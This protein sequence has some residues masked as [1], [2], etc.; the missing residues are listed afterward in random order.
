MAIVFFVSSAGDT[1]LAKA[2]INTLI[3][4]GVD[5]EIHLIPLTSAA[6]ERTKDLISSSNIRRVKLS[7]IL[8]IDKLTTE[9]KLEPKELS[10]VCDYIKQNNIQH[11]YIGVPSPLEEDIPYQIAH[12][13]E[14]PCTIAY[15]YMFTAQ[16]KHHF[17]DH[18][19]L[20]ANKKNCNYAVPLPMAKDDILKFNREADVHT[21]GHLSIDRTMVNSTS[22]NI[23]PIKEQLMLKEQE[24]LI[25]ISGTTQP[26]EVDNTFVEAILSEIATGKYPQLQIRFGLHPGIQDFDSYLKLILETCDNYQLTASQFK[27]ILPSHIEQKLQQA[28]S[29]EHPFILRTDVT[30]ADACHAADKIAQAVPGALLNEAAIKGKPSY[31]HVDSSKP[32]LPETY[33]SESII[34]FFK[35]ARQP[36]PHTH[37]ELG[38]EEESAA[39]HMANLLFV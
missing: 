21:I 26:A 16:E 30:G 28:I 34:L 36:Q 6:E 33:F 15:E 37:K 13:L 24:E 12:A 7:E 39:N 22:I 14:I 2:T 18:L 1:D 11:A 31:F 10:I 5:N 29:N 27:I 17:W 8:K 32:Y 3:E 25:F 4:K 19:S 9:K 35:A 23:S 38:I 20:L